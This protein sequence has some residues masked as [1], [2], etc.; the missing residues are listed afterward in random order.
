ERLHE[1]SYFGILGKFLESFL[2][3]IDPWLPLREAADIQ[4]DDQ[5][6]LIGRSQF[7]AQDISVGQLEFVG[8]G[9]SAK[10][11]TQAQRQPNRMKSAHVGRFD[12]T[13]MAGKGRKIAAKHYLATPPAAVSC[14]PAYREGFRLSN[15]FARLKVDRLRCRAARRRSA[16]LSSGWPAIVPGPGS[17]PNSRPARPHCR[18][19][20]VGDCRRS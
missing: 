9:V 17:R 3:K 12:N 5:A 15:S 8:G 1:W 13:S 4:F 14:C 10:Q 20:R 19:G 18:P 11:P 2:R 7:A 6:I 16:A